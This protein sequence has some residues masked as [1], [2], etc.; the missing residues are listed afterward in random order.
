MG[1]RF[2][3]KAIQTWIKK[4]KNT[5]P[6]PGNRGRKP[7]KPKPNDRKKDKDR[8]KKDEKNDAE[9]D[10]EKKGK[11]K[12]DKQDDESNSG[13]KKDECKPNTKKG[14]SKRAAQRPRPS[15]SPNNSGKRQKRVDDCEA[16]CTNKLKPLAGYEKNRM[17]RSRSKKCHNQK[18]GSKCELVCNAGYIESV[19]ESKCV[20]KG[21]DD[22]VW[23]PEL[24]CAPLRCFGSFGNFYL[25]I[26]TKFK[27]FGREHE[28]VAY[29]V[30]FDANR[31][32][33][34]Y[35]A[36]AFDNRYNLKFLKQSRRG[37]WVQ[38]PC[39]ELNGRQAS[40]MLRSK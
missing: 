12:K 31:K 2:G 38:H 4:I 39:K 35:S 14:R 17:D 10:R 40:K 15:S 37:S 23:S 30:K 25:S 7:N 8:G 11:N 13:K 29:F 34:V 32:L 20:K 26:N 36:Y 27:H 5:K 1:K 6:K 21:Q 24:Q 18:I 19:V 16:K 22:A 9:Q 3:K 33:P 28:L